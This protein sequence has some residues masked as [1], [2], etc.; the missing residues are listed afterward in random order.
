[1]FDF[2]SVINNLIY[3]IIPL[4]ISYS[5]E[6]D[7]E[8]LSRPI[9]RVSYHRES[10]LFVQCYK[11]IHDAG[12]EGLYLQDVIR[13]LPISHLL[14]R[15]VPVT[16]EKAGLIVSK[17]ED[18]HH[19]KSKKLIRRFKFVLE[20]ITQRSVRVIFVCR[21][22]ASCYL[23]GSRSKNLNFDTHKPKRPQKRKF[24]SSPNQSSVTANGR[25]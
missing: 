1:M 10:P 2:S 21:L 13:S 15:R 20:D 14:G 7:E 4:T 17:L 23:K 8:D 11:L 22:T 6:E 19:H 12:L 9:R 5:V 16:L 3:S 25:L 18:H 24:P